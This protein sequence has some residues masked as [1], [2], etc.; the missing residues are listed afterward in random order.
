MRAPSRKPRRSWRSARRKPWTARGRAG[1]DMS[2]ALTRVLG[3]D[4]GSRRIGLARSDRT[5]TIA[6]PLDVLLRSGDHARDHRALVDRAR[7]EEAGRI[8]VGLPRSLSGDEGPAAQAVR[9]E[10][11]ELR[12]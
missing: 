11:D 7:A 5:G 12:A 9:A 8:V 2:T 1:D 4:L 6:T 3:V 10:V